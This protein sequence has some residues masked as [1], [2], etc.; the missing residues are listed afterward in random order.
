[1]T[2]NT[3]EFMRAATWMPHSFSRDAWTPDADAAALSKAATKVRDLVSEYEK[4]Q[5]REDQVAAARAV[6]ERAKREL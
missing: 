6:V 3:L 5:G 2:D 1:M 4:P